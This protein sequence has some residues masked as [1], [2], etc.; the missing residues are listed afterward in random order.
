MTRT[1]LKVTGMTCGH[2][3]QSVQAALEGADGVRSV[4]VDLGEGSAVVDH[5]EQRATPESLKRAV[6]EAG[7]GAVATG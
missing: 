5:D 7:Y 1:K 4:R 3:V 2:C 6:E